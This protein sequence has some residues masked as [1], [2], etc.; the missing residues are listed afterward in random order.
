M[1][2]IYVSKIIDV[3]DKQLSEFNYKLLHH[4]HRNKDFLCKWK[5]DVK[6]ESKMCKDIK[7]INI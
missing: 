2:Q 7:K 6:A 1:E 3:E 5:V 4:I